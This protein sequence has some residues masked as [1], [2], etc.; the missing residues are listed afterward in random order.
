MD[1]R[2]DERNSTQARR[3]SFYV[4]PHGPCRAIVSFM[5][6][7]S[8]VRDVDEL[9]AGHAQRTA[10]PYRMTRGARLARPLPGLGMKHAFV[11]LIYDDLS[12]WRQHEGNRTDRLV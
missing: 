6:G 9:P 7:N 12:D 10:L 2:I 5:R 1:R 11:V 8:K 4:C 3:V